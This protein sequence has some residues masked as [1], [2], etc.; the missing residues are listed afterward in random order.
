MF[1][2]AL[3]ATRNK[4]KALQVPEA[5]V[6]R[7]ADGDWQ[8]MVEQ[9]EAGE[10]KA[11]EVAVKNISDGKAVIEGL[12]KNTIRSGTRVV[13]RGAFF[14]QSELAKGGFEIHNH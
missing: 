6:L 11:V 8:V 13:T 4:S 12:E 3:I 5:A 14:V 9:D 7:S 2:T 1:V 10:F